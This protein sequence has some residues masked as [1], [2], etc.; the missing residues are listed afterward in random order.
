MAFGLIFGLLVLVGV[1][2]WLRV[3]LQRESVSGVETTASPLSSAVQ[4]LVATAGGVYL[5]IVAL[6]SFLKLETPDKV[7]LMQASVDPLALT[8][9][10][11]AIIQPIIIRIYNKFKSSR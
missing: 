8:A 5:A 6:T 4:E 7:T 9:I 1:S 10:G 2:L 11:L 3:R